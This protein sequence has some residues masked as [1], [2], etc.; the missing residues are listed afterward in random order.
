M[1]ITLFMTKTMK[2]NVI[3]KSFY[4]TLILETMCPLPR[5]NHANLFPL[6]LIDY[7]NRITSLKLKI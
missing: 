6:L 7:V 5:A 2:I 4:L 1:I 3:F